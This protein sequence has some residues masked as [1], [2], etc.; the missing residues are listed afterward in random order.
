[1]KCKCPECGEV[2]DAE[3]NEVDEK[4]VKPGD[5]KK[6]PEM[7]A[8]RAFFVERFRKIKGLRNAFKCYTRD[9]SSPEYQEALKR[10]LKSANPGP[11]FLPPVHSEQ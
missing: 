11:K 5:D 2:F 1:M 7:R 3:E 10:Y 9:E 4:G 8:R 6:S